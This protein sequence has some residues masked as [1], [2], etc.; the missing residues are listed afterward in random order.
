MFFTEVTQ[1]SSVEEKHVNTDDVSDTQQKKATA[2][3]TAE[4]KRA[5]EKR[6][7]KKRIQM[8]VLS[9][10]AVIVIV[11]AFVLA[12]MPKSYKIDDKTNTAGSEVV[13]ENAAANETGDS[14]NSDEVNEKKQDP[15]QEI[16]KYFE[17]TEYYKAENAERYVEYFKANPDMTI[18]EIVWRVNANLDKLMY[19]FD[20]PVSGYDDPYIIVNKYYTVSQGYEPP[21]M[22]E[23]DGHLLREETGI[24]FERMQE[25]AL[26]EGYNINIVAG[27]RSFEEQ[28]ELYNG[29]LSTDSEENVDR[30]TQRPG[31]SEHHTGMAMD[32]SGTDCNELLDFV[33]SPEYP[34][35]MDNCYKYG[36]II[37]YPEGT[38]DITGYE[39]KP[40]HL[41]YVG[42]EVSTDMKEKNIKSY[43]EYY[44]KYLG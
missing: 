5:T 18:D 43:E 40:W 38:E 9:I 24:A 35:V 23:F 7:R 4:R 26:A 36:F 44:A 12:V 21:D 42:V 31:H 20:I 14:N 15:M 16:K 34:W 28:S 1:M 39:F 30:Y 11:G 22:K 41:R 29:Y 19:G 17:K 25:D 2:K 32:I 3:K 37:R 27:Y 6:R 10:C 8:I 33:N 13:S